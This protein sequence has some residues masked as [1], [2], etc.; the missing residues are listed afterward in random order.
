[1]SQIH[2]GANGIR[3][4]QVEVLFQKYDK[5]ISFN[6]LGNHKNV[7]FAFEM[8]SICCASEDTQTGSIPYSST[9]ED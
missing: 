5:K 2:E 6:E 1:M 7:Y 9:R 4:Y 3:I 8:V